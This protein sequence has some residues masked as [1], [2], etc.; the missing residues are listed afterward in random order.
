MW[1]SDRYWRP[2]QQIAKHRS[3]PALNAPGE[4][5]HSRAL[6]MRPSLVP[7]ACAE[8]PGNTATVQTARFD[9]IMLNTL[10]PF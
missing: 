3:T 1:P 6:P 4:G 2:T 10:M 8:A 7:C 5:A 9:V